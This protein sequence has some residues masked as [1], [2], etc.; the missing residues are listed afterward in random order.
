MASEVP[1]PGRP[2][3][4]EWREQKPSS[5]RAH[6][7]PPPLVPE[8]HSGMPCSGSCT[9][10]TSCQ[11]G[12]GNNRHAYVPAVSTAPPRVRPDPGEFRQFR[13]SSSERSRRPSYR[14][15][16]GGSRLLLPAS[17]SVPQTGAE[18]APAC[19]GCL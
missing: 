6:R 17:C 3:V 18:S 13:Q 2:L 5:R 19:S 1:K 9:A 15:P 12:L 4:P 14:I 10:A 11:E 16:T 7:H 8:L